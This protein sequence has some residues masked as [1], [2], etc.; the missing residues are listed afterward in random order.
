MK[1]NN[2]NKNE[3]KYDVAVSKIIIEFRTKFGDNWSNRE[4]TYIE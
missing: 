4:E 3:L 2:S 1:Y